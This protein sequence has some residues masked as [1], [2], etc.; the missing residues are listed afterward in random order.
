MALPVF[1]K[2]VSAKTAPARCPKMT[3]NGWRMVAAPIRLNQ[4]Q[5]LNLRQCIH[6]FSTSS[7]RPP[8][9]HHPSTPSLL[10]R[11]GNKNVT[12]TQS[13][14][15][16]NFDRRFD[17]IS[18][19]RQLQAVT[20][21]HGGLERIVANGCANDSFSRWYAAQHRVNRET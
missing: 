2:P 10:F 6:G 16:H 4:K 19:L 7:A 21:Q 1:P 9:R 8:P 11:A 14:F 15:Q 13:L 12:S 3:S 17:T 18:Q 5:N 20:Q